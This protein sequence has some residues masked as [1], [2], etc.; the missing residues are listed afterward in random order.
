MDGFLKCS[1]KKCKHFKQYLA[2]KN[3]QSDSSNITDNDSNH[4]DESASTGIENP[5]SVQP[6]DHYDDI[7]PI[8][9]YYKKYGYNLTKIVYPFKMDPETQE[10]WIRRLD[11]HYDLPERITPEFIAGFLCKHGSSFDPND[12]NLVECSSNIIIYTESSE[13]VYPIKT[14]SRKTVDGCKCKQQADTHKLLLWHI[15]KGKMIDYMFLSSYMHNMRSNGLPKNGLFRSR[16]ERLNSIGVKSSLVP[17]DLT[18]ATNGFISKITFHSD[19]KV[20]SCPKCGIS[21]KYLVADGKSDGPTKRKVDHLKELGTADNDTDCL[22]QGSHYKDISFLHIYQER[23]S[24]CHLLTG[25]QSLDDFLTEE[26]LE[27]ENGRLIVELICRI[28]VTWADE[29]PKEYTRFIGNICKQTSVAGL[30]QVTSDLPL[31]Y[32]E[33]FCQESLDI[34]SVNEVDKLDFLQHQL[35]AFWPMLTNILDLE[36]RKYLPPDVCRIVVKIIQIRRNTFRNAAA[37]NDND[38]TDWQSPEEEHPTQFYPEFPIFRYP[39]VYTVNGQKDSDFCNK[40]FDEKRDFSYGVFSIGCCCHLNISYGFE[41]ML[42]K[43]SA[44]N[45]FRFLMCRDVDMSNLEG[46]IFDHAC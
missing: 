2:H 5:Q 36:G 11:G 1:S 42:C 33:S 8:D 30:L 7:E 20:F 34:R 22:P 26:D 10:V 29:I 41:L 15:G 13:K 32:L 40:A 25:A 6:P 38:Y 12:D 19:L 18:R 21:P 17:Q 27:T 14:Y 23:Q 9:E 44:H 24:I 4:S 43:E 28:A 45:F 39:K 16:C 31:T 46:M 3:D 35:P 37:R